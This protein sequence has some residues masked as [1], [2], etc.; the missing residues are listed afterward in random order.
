[1]FMTNS[2]YQKEK[3]ISH[4]LIVEIL[5]SVLT[6]YKKS[7]WNPTPE[8][9]EDNDALVQGNLYHILIGAPQIVA[10]CQE[11]LDKFFTAQEQYQKAKA[12]KKKAKASTKIAEAPYVSIEYMDG[13][14]HIADFGLT[15]RNKAYTE[16]KTAINSGDDDYIVSADEFKNICDM[17][18][19]LTA[20][21]IY[22]SVHNGAE[23]IG[24]ERTLL[25][26]IDGYDYKCK[27]DRLLK[28][29]NK[30]RII[31]W[32]TTKETSLDVIACRGESMEYHIQA[33]LYKRIVS[34]VYEVPFDDV[35]MVFVFQNKENPELVYALDFEND[36]LEMAKN[37]REMTVADF[38]ERLSRGN[39][40]V[41]FIPIQTEIK[42]F[43]HFPEKFTDFVGMV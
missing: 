38:M 35:E 39:G 20:H 8:E 10:N 26:K 15:R 5:D 9:K 4:S 19:F 33:E 2:Q 42:H 11:Y 12:D 34:L 17:V 14:I 30:Y 31:D 23:I 22:N 28:V 3:A 21:P 24:D 13:K 36:S 1:M 18:R 29:G 27:I 32:K 6:A 16:I 7:P 25:T 37:Q 43:R 40:L 41:D